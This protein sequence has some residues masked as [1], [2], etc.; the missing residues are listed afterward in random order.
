[1]ADR[2]GRVANYTKNDTIPQI[3][4]YRLTADTLRKVITDTAEAD[5][6]EKEVEAG[7]QYPLMSLANLKACEYYARYMGKRLPKNNAESRQFLAALP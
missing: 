2:D 6:I 5:H 4:Q 1:M 3:V 7:R